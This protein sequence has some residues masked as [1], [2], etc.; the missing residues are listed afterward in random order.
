M[1]VCKFLTATVGYTGVF[2]HTIMQKT[3]CNSNLIRMD[4]INL[5]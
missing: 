2:E 5:H 4:S 1:S 3:M